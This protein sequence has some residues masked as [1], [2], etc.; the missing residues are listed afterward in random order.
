MSVIIKDAVL[1]IIIKDSSNLKYFWTAGKLFLAALL[2][3][4]V[5]LITTFTIRHLSLCGCPLTKTANA[6]NL[7]WTIDDE[8]IFMIIV[9]T[10]LISFF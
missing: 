3:F 1:S 10:Q 4:R 2:R 6:I 7:S 9:H 8:V 5:D